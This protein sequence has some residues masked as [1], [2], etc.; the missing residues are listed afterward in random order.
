[1][2]RVGGI[3]EYIVI[4]NLDIAENILK[5]DIYGIELKK[6]NKE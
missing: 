4:V 6:A 1:M 3:F 5:R 2:F